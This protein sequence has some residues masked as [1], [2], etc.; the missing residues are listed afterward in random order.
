MS[1]RVGVIGAGI[2]GADHIARLATSIGGAEVSFVADID[3]GRAA[4]AATD[5]VLTTLELFLNARYGYTTQCEVVAERGTASLAEPAL[6]ATAADGL[7]AAQAAEAMTSS[8]RNNGELTKAD[9]S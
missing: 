6:L 3:P 7:R 4:A 2:M 9:Y 8:L 5:G 1:I